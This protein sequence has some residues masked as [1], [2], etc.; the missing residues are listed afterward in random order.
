MWG[1]RICRRVHGACIHNHTLIGTITPHSQLR[2]FILSDFVLGSLTIRPLVHVSSRGR[3]V[4]DPKTKS[5]KMNCRNWECGV[6]VPIINEKKDNGA[7]GTLIGTGTVSLKTPTGRGAEVTAPCV[8]GVK[9]PKT[10]SLKMNCR[11]WECGVI[12]PIINEKKTGEKGKGPETH[13]AVTSAPLPVGV[14]N[15]TRSHRIPSCGSS[16]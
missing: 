11:N 2:Q 8:S 16:S 4:K 15:D 7:A 5:L 1:V 6:I 13:G 9:D 10:K 12:V 3:I 14:F